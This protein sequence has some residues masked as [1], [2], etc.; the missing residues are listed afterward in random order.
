[1]PKVNLLKQVDD[2]EVALDVAEKIVRISTNFCVIS[3]ALRSLSLT[4]YV[5]ARG[6]EFT[7][8]VDK[9]KSKRVRGFLR[10]TE[11][12]AIAQDMIMQWFAGLARNLLR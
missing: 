5:N 8:A 11:S 9:I 4:R 7:N 12:D 2:P 1:M 10:G 6:K 3:A